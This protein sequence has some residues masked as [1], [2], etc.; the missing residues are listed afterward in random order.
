MTSMTS[1]RQTRFG[2]AIPQKFPDGVVD[3]QYITEF[4]TTVESLGYD[5]AWVGEGVFGKVP[6]LEPM[7]LLSYAAALTSRVKLGVSA[8]T[9]PLWNPIFLAKAVA[10]L[11]QL[12]NGRFILGLTVGV[13]REDYPA[14]GLRPEHRLTRFIEGLDLMKRLWTSDNV[15][16]KGKFWEMEDVSISPRPV[17]EPHPPV[18]FG[19]RALPALRRSVKYGDGWMGSGA[20]S[21]AEFREHMEILRGFMAEEGKGQDEFPLSKRVYLALDPN[22][23]RALRKLEEMMGFIYGDPTLAP[24]VS[25]YGDREEVA[26]GLREL[27]AEGVDLILLAPA[28]D[29]RGQAELLANQVL[30]RL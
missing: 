25:I 17:Q 15:T 7:P 2:V 30:P 26:E 5:S 27:M 22:K 14:F 21:T 18:W 13:H 23:D 20:T 28:S 8:L 11:D 19:S 1:K 4:L 29:P 24:K 9:F 6:N 12:S 3:T 16:F 10:S